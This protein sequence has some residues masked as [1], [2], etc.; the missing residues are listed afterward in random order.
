MDQ[1]ESSFDHDFPASQP[2]DYA[3]I[4]Q[5]LRDELNTAME[6]LNHTRENLAAVAHEYG[7]ES[8]ETHAASR[9]HSEALAALEQASMRFS[10]FVLNCRI[11]ADFGPSG[12]EARSVSRD[13]R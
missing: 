7:T 11:P 3:E 13:N 8:R 2:P 6:R 9:E 12:A 5:R 4:E 10:E 1:T